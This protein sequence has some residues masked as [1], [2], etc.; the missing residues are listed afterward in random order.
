M[1][2]FLPRDQ[3]DSLFRILQA[4]GY[5]CLAPRSSDGAVQFLATHSIDEL[6][7]G[8]RDHQAPGEYRLH[9][10]NDQRLF[11]WAVGPQALKPL[12][13]HPRETLWQAS[14]AAEG[15]AFRAATAGD[16]Q[17]LAVIG[18]RACDLAA[19]A[20]QEQH[21]LKDPEP[22]TAF[23]RRRDALFIVGVDCTHPAATCFC[24]ATGDGPAVSQGYDLRLHELDE[25]FLIE[26][27]SPAGE[28]IL[29]QLDARAAEADQQRTAEAQTAQAI[30]TQQRAMPPGD[31]TDKLRA[32]WDSSAWSDIAERC[33]SCGNC[34]AVCPTCFCHRQEDDLT[35]LTDTLTHRRLWDSCFSSEHSYI[36]GIVIRP[37]TRSRYRQWLTHKLGTWHQQYGRS[38]CVG[39]GRCITWC[40]VGIDITASVA[41][42]LE[43]A[44]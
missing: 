19:L 32:R 10:G 26:A 2:D 44:P 20:L 8:L 41:E 18:A 5:L 13:F 21:F 43:S 12:T 29:G 4:A 16:S 15:L 6:T 17:P 27:G 35:E 14:P 38:G 7:P 11:A 34:T 30:Q 31:L 3:F 28:K 39:C 9:T 1:K 37:D 23:Q 36:H 22:D 42:V 40:P 33:L 24:H 25:G